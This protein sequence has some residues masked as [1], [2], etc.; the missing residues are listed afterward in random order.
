[1]ILHLTFAAY[2]FAHLDAIAARILG[3]LLTPWGY[4]ARHRVMRGELSTS[5]EAVE[6]S[7]WQQLRYAVGED[8]QPLAAPERVRAPFMRQPMYPVYE[9][10]QVHAGPTRLVLNP[11]W[12]TGS[13]EIPVAQVG[14]LVATA[15]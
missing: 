15:T 7:R 6:S 1:M 13:G 8:T 10:T 2:C 4:P 3:W 12:R 9:T 11:S 5:D 14:E